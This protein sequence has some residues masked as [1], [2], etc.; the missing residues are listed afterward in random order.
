[1]IRGKEERRKV[2]RA[3]FCFRGLRRYGVGSVVM[4]REASLRGQ[5]LPGE[6]ERGI[7][8]PRWRKE[9][10]V[11]QAEALCLETPEGL[12]KAL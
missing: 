8:V 6:S 3:Q 5:A 10:G 9:G 12:G 11:F 7:G 1:M 2:L 4:A